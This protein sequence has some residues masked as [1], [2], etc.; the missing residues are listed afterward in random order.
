YRPAE[1]ALRRTCSCVPTGVPGTRLWASPA[2]P[3]GG[4]GRGPPGP[5][6]RRRQDLWGARS[7]HVVGGKDL[8][9]GQW[10]WQGSQLRGRH[11]HC[12]ASLLSCRVLKAM[13][14]FLKHSD[15]LK[16]TAHIG[17]LSS[18]PHYWKL[19]TF[20]HRYRVK[21][22]IIYPQFEGTSLNDI[23]LLKLSSSVTYNKYIQPI[24]VMISSSKFQ[25]QTNCWVTGWGDI[26]E[27]QGE[28]LQ[29]VQV[30][31]INN[32]RCDYLFQQPSILSYN[33]NDMIC[34]GSEDG[35]RDACDSGGPLACE[36]RG[37]WI[38][39]G[40]VSWG[41]GCGRPNRP[42][43]YTNISAYFNWIRT[44]MAHS[45]IQRSAPCLQLLLPLLWLA[46]LL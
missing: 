7:A 31:I 40:I 2:L 38:Q 25:N 5:R 10:P 8:E 20:Y 45:S 39:V 17:E 26:Q 37:L 6:G 4:G 1:R 29:E 46:S 32:S 30:S 14:C 33:L 9:P 16:W 12:G 22:I 11:Q 23:A 27:N 24:C 44:L 35:S 19:W 13:H 41:S 42:G 21:D 34:A 36:K 15:P 18:R 3:A 28:N 43:V